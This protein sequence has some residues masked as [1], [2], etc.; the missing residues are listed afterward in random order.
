LP[1]EQSHDLGSGGAEGFQYTDFSRL[2]DHKG[3]Q[4]AGDA[5]GRYKHDEEKEVVHNVLLD[6]DGFE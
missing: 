3:D 6:E 2:L 4:R 1:Q 5:K